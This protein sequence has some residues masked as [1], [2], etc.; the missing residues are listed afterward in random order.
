MNDDDKNGNLKDVQDYSKDSN[1][2]DEKGYRKLDDSVDFNTMKCDTISDTSETEYNKDLGTKYMNE[3]IDEELK[4]VNNHEMGY[5][6]RCNKCNENNNDFCSSNE[7]ENYGYSE[8]YDEIF[9]E[10][11]NDKGLEDKHLENSSIYDEKMNEDLKNNGDAV[12]GILEFIKSGNEGR[13]EIKKLS[14][15]D[16]S[17]IQ[18]LFEITEKEIEKIEKTKTI[19]NRPPK[20]EVFDGKK[21]TRGRKKKVYTENDLDSNDYVTYLDENN[22][23]RKFPINIINGKK[24]YLC[25]KEFCG[26]SFPSKSRIKRHY[27]VHT[28]EKPHKCLNRKCNKSFSRKDNMIQHYKNH[29]NFTRKTNNYNAI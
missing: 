17:K 27:V 23:E 4:A 22:I 8:I 3:F 13:S 1:D 9:T 20:K 16:K 2:L 26:R 6:N 10:D 19:K 5:E 25:P 14:E 21:E 29:C 24:N 12:E 18:Y 7:S 11:L 28:G 15:D